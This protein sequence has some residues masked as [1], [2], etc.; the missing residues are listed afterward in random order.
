MYVL[1]KLSLKPKTS[2]LIIDFK[3]I[4]IIIKFDPSSFTYEF[5]KNLSIL[6][7]KFYQISS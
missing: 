6:T 5:L 4:I 1:W 7:K 2:H 3:A